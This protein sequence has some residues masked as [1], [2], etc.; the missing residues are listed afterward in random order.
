MVVRLGS[1]GSSPF[2]L[3]LMR[4][5]AFYAY[6]L[7]GIVCACVALQGR[8]FDPYGN[9]TSPNEPLQTFCVNYEITQRTVLAAPIEKN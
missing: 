8:A 4:V 9:P 3:R 6:V 2:R 1:L 5:S 7:A